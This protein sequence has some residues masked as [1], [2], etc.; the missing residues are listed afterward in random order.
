MILIWLLVAVN[1]QV[2][3]ALDLLV[4][5]EVWAQEGV[6]LQDWWAGQNPENERTTK[7][8]ERRVGGGW[9]WWLSLICW[10]PQM[11]ML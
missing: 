11:V 4:V 7:T 8:G 5:A 3:L 1:M 10:G 9:I 6:R 2:V